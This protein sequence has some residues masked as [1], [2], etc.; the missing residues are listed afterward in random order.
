MDKG[1]VKSGLEHSVDPLGRGRIEVQARRGINQLLII[2]L[3]TD[4]RSVVPAELEPLDPATFEKVDE[5]SG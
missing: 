2:R 5:T 3:R 1:Q 4:H